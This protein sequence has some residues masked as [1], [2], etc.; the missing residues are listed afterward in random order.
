MINLYEYADHD[1]LGLAALIRRGEVSSSEVL[2]A[3]IA[4]IEQHNPALNA[5]IRKRYDSARGEALQVTPE[6][7]FAGVPFLLKDLIATIA[8]EP[9]GYGNR[10]LAALTMPQDSEL[11][12]RFRAAG[13][14]IVGRTNTPEFGLT[15]YT[16][17]QAFGPTRNP[18]SAEHSPGGS[19]GGSAAAVAARMVPLASGGDGGGSIR[20]P[21][22]CCGLFGFKPSRGMTPT[23]PEFG[24]VWRG[25]AIEHVLTRSVRDSAAMLD[26]TAGIDPGAPYAAPHCERTFLESASTPPG[27]LR[28]AFTSKPLLGGH[29]VHPDCVAAAESSARLLESLGHQVEEAAPPVDREAYALAFIT[30]I[31]CELRAEL[32][33]FARTSGHALRA[34]DV[35]PATWGLAL[36]GRTVKAATF[37]NAVRTL[38]LA[39]RSMA[40]FF[41]QHDVLLTPTLATPPAVIGSLQP[42]AGEK[43]LLRIVNK[44]NAGWLLRSLGVLGALAEKTF[45]Y[46]PFT[47]LFNATGQPAMSVPLYWNS[48]GLPVGVQFVGKLGSDAQLFQLAGQLEQSQPWFKRGPAMFT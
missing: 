41:E 27:R 10:S 33:F 24:E 32:E 2:E 35:E 14:V 48:A 18:W 5:V 19:S 3:A 25:F 39:A 45:D 38:Q 43:R 34:A 6:A 47:P 46:I 30:V 21:A 4:R 28:I 8:G 31:A 9:T 1:G 17:P 29:G 7:P 26:A 42:S 13:L 16:E 37:I 23:G 20:I 40:P 11:V 36:L 44:M 15:P 12:R 22:S